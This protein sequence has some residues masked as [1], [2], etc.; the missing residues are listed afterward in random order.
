MAMV[1]S[2]LHNH[3]AIAGQSMLQVARVTVISSEFEKGKMR[4]RERNE[5]IVHMTVAQYSAS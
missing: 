1:F 5:V 2:V 3:L 4:E